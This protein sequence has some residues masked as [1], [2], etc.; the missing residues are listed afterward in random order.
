[1]DHMR[2]NWGEG[3]NRALSLF[4]EGPSIAGALHFSVVLFSTL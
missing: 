2:R 1:M 3:G 4:G